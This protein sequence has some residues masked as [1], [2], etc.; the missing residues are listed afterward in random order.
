MKIKRGRET[1]P[2]RVFLYGVEGIG[3]SSW[4]NQ[5]PNT[6]F[7]DIEDGLSD[8]DCAKSPHIIDLDQFNEA[9]LFL[10]ESKHD[11]QTVAI[12]SA[13]WLEGLI[14]AEVA[15]AAGKKSIADIGFGAGYKQALS[16]WDKILSRLDWLRR[17]RDM[18]VI[19]LA[20]SQVKRHQDPEQESY[21][22]FTPALHDLASAMIREWCDEVLFA[23]YRVFI[24]KEDQGFGKERS[25]A[26]GSGERYLRTQES[27]ACLAKNRLGMPP[28]IEFSWAAYASFFSSVKDV[29]NG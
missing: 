4:A 20:H 8:I 13:D 6:L 25:I 19:F 10:A 11:F 29:S 3:K 27:A 7:L 9:L 2:R 5:A 26:M 24:R 15:K 18:G 14:H 28:E 16:Y 21:D 17:E 23:S 1:K 12:D 22:R